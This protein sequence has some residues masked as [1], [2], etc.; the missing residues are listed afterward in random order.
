MHPNRCDNA[1]PVEALQPSRSNQ[2]E[3]L[4]RRDETQN[5]SG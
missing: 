5:G 2:N 1:A 3:H 4:T